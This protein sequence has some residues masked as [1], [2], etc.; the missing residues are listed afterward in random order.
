MSC[1][2]VIPSPKRL[3]SLSKSSDWGGDVAM[4]DHG[5]ATFSDDDDGAKSSE[6]ERKKY[7]YEESRGG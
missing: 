7:R 2:Q 5:E 4:D 1:A 6:A 3:R